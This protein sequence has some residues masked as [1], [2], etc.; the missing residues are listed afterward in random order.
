MSRMAASRPAA[1]AVRLSTRAPT[2]RSIPDLEKA[3]IHPTYVRRSESGH[4]CKLSSAAP[5]VWF[6]LCQIVSQGFV[7]GRQFEQ[8]L[9]RLH[10][11]QE[12]RDLS[13]VHGLRAQLLGVH[14][15]ETAKQAAR[16][17]NRFVLIK[18]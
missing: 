9:R 2:F 13:V 4:S 14:F 7:F 15:S 6:L 12:K 17:C 16:F 5:R 1:D 3:Q 11:A 18:S 8:S 10:V